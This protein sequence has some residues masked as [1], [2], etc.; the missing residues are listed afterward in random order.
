ML[1][2]SERGL[3]QVMSS[4]KDELI[5]SFRNPQK[6]IFQF[7]KVNFPSLETIFLGEITNFKSK[8]NFKSYSFQDDLFLISPLEEGLFKLDTSGF[9]KVTE[10]YFLDSILYKGELKKIFDLGEYA[11]LAPWQ[12][13]QYQSDE[14]L[15]ATQISDQET[16][17]LLKLLN[18]TDPN[19]PEF[20]IVLYKKTGDKVS[21]RNLEGYQFSK[22]DTETQTFLGFTFESK[23]VVISNLDSLLIN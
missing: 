3:H 23:A 21:W 17:F 7:F 19:S 4:N 2:M 5:V 1:P 6:G 15:S 16:F 20:E 11:S 22:L 12:R 9:T 10:L 13:N 8:N 18:R 14:I